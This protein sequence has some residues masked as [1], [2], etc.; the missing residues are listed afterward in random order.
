M[1]IMKS[2]VATPRCIWMDAKAVEYQLCPLKQNCD[3]CD[4]H[5]RMMKGGQHAPSKDP[6]VVQVRKPEA[7]VLHFTPGIQYLHRHLWIRRSGETRVQLGMDT[8]LWQIFSTVQKV[9][10]ASKGTELHSGQ[11]CT[12]LQ[13]KDQIIYLRTPAAG[14]IVQ[15]NPLFDTESIHDHHLYLEPEA[16]L[17]FIE[18]D[19][20]IDALLPHYHSKEIYLQQVNQDVR[21]FD[22]FSGDLGESSHVNGLRSSHLD[23]RSFTDFLKEISDNLVFA[24]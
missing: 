13:L 1:R 7:A 8:F 6:A 4:F 22:R 21:R 19:T 14:R 15:T 17:W 16:E 10:T 9:I 12:W 24:C 11:C 3:R 5:Q 23:R 20:P 2:D 18:M